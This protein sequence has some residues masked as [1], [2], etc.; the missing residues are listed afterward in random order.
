M[1]LSFYSLS[2]TLLLAAPSSHASSYLYTVKH[3]INPKNPV[4]NIWKLKESSDLF[5]YYQQR[6]C[7]G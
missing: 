5:V 2:E 3:C 7:L 4:L 1:P 6:Q